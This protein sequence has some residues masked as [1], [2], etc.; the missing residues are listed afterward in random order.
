MKIVVQDGKAKYEYEL[1][2][3]CTMG[4]LKACVLDSTGIPPEKQKI[5]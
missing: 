1:A 3:A 2:D 5:L 4:D